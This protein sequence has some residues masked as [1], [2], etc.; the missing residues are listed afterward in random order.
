M[1]ATSLA[2]AAEETDGAATTVDPVVIGVIALGILLVLLLGL[3]S[4]GKGRE[5]S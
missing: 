1:L 2:Q 4:F 5:H 3:L